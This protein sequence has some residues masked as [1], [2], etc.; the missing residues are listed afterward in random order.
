MK[1]L[2]IIL[3]LFISVKTFGQTAPL[4]PVQLTTNSIW[5]E[6]STHN[7]WGYNGIT[8]L[9]Y[10]LVDSVQLFRHVKNTGVA[11]GSYTNSNITVGLD[12]RITAAANGTGG[13]G[14]ST[15]SVAS[16]NGFTGSSSGGTTPVLTLTTSISG[17]LKGNATAISAAISGTDYL[18]PN[19]NG[20][21]LTNFTS[22]QITTALSFT[23]YNATNPSGYIST[24]PNTAVTPGSYTNTNITV[25]ADGR[26]TAASNGS[27]GGGLATTNFVYNE[28]PAGTINGTNVTFTLANTP[29]TG[30]VELFINGLQLP[31][32]AYSITGSTITYATAPSTAGG[33][34]VLTANYLK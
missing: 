21:A 27:G 8:Y 29:T 30:K 9:W 17:L 5:Y 23:P 4:N 11:A 32:S 3:L 13:G 19:G 24:I 34:D 1:K 15:I 22:S 26:I 28:T 25:G 33:N 20:S 12:G 7:R 14:V 31:S 6:P 16:A 2:I 18:A 10:Q